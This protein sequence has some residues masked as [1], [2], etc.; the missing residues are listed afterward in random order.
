MLTRRDLLRALVAAGAAAPLLSACGSSPGGGGVTQVSLAKSGL[1]RAGG[2]PKAAAAAA[3]SIATFAARLYPEIAGKAG[4]IV[5]SPYSIAVALGMTLNGAAG[6]TAQ[7]M[8]DVLT[9]DDLDAFNTGLNSLT[10][11]LEGL[12]GK[13]LVLDS[14][15]SL[16]GQQGM[17]W[18]QPFLDVLARDYG[19]GMRQ[20][21]YK[22]ATEGARLAINEWTS[23]QTHK[24]IP[25]II[26][27]GV[28][29]GLTRLVLVN[30][31]YLKAAWLLPFEKELTT[32]APFHLSDGSTVDVPMMGGADGSFERV[33]GKGFQ[34]LRLPYDGGR[35]AMTVVLPDAGST[36]DATV[37]A[38]AM[39]G[40]PTDS[41]GLRLPR[42]KFR[43][44]AGL[45]EVLRKLGMPT[46]FSE[47]ADFS[48]MTHDERLHIAA[49]L[50]E[51]FVAVDEDGTEAAAATAVVMR[52]TSARIE[53][54]I[55][56]VDRPFL[57]AI[58]DVQDNT[59]LFVGRVDD[60]R[61]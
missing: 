12:A 42:W 13:K 3:R 59:P 44:Q 26:P 25:S 30:A 36:V 27:E 10:Q 8:R 15:N 53:P 24:K 6:T 61:A 54:T 39:A 5:Y 45:G 50:H 56:T 19:T 60:P 47:D 23:D 21:D 52:T 18:E 37:F 57:F 38:E 41:V 22:T 2:D 1:S 40:V 20:V 34:A 49:V 29:D 48:G 55:V 35:L 17:T 58:H 16:W 32:D 9:V 28:L 4:N 33:V 14:A 11:R 46:A 51:A 7:E 31:I 43:L